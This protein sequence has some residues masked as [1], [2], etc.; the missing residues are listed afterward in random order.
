MGVLPDQPSKF[1]QL[2]SDPETL[3][4][5]TQTNWRPGVSLRFLG[6]TADLEELEERGADLAEFRVHEVRGDDRL[7]PWNYRFEKQP[8]PLHAWYYA[9]P[10]SSNH[11]QSNP[12]FWFEHISVLT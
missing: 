2:R 9:V 5:I 11:L 4:L 10:G 12:V 1:I 7:I 3:L 8:Y 6:R